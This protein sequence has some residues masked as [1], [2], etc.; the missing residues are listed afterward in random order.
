MC[1]RYYM[2]M[3]PLLRPYVE[4]ANRSPLNSMLS[5]KLNRSMI[6]EGEVRPGDI[7]PVIATSRKGTMAAYPMSFGFSSPKGGLILNARIETVSQKPMFS[8]AWARRRC[9]IPA[10]GYFEWQHS[11]GNNGK[12]IIGDKYSFMAADSKATWLCGLYRIDDGLPCFVI[13]TKDASPGILSIHDRMPLIMPD[14]AVRRW[15]DP[16]ADP[17]ELSKLAVNNLVYDKVN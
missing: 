12:K 16:Y 1:T 14:N 10:S 17:E 3:S 11:A 6:T 5:S 13:I 8:Q 7:A 9:I 4:A 2:E 15:I